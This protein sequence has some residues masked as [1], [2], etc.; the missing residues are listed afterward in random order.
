MRSV[1]V[2]LLKNHLSEYIRLAA[3]GETVLVTDRDE[4]V[5]ELGP[6]RNGRALAVGDA[7]LAEAVRKGWVAPPVA[8][9]DTPPGRLPVTSWRSLQK[10][11]AEDREDER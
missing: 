1:G 4:V 8:P 10:E 9:S 7:L 2:K 11:L 3:T 6:P 5:A